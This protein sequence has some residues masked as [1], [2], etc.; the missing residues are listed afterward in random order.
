MSPAVPVTRLAALTRTVHKC[1]A[2]MWNNTYYVCINIIRWWWEGPDGM[3]HNV[4]AE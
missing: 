2:N 4:R 3:G 1:I